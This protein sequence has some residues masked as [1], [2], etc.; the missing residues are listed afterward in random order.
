M[1]MPGQAAAMPQGGQGSQPAATDRVWNVVTAN[2]VIG[3][4]PGMVH[5]FE[6]RGAYPHWR[7]SLAH[8]AVAPQ[9][10]GPAPARQAQGLGLYQPPVAQAG[11]LP[12]AQAAPAADLLAIARAQAEQA[13]ADYVRLLALE[14]DRAR[15]QAAA[16]AAA[17]TAA[18]AQAAQAQAPAVPAQAARAQAAP[19]QAAPAQAAHAAH[20]AQ[21]AQAQAQAAEA[22][23]EGE[24]RPTS[25][26]VDMIDPQNWPEHRRIM[27]LGNLP[28]LVTVQDIQ[29]ICTRAGVPN[30]QVHIFSKTGSSGLKAARAIVPNPAWNML[31]LLLE[32]HGHL[33]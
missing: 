28:S 21:A 30:V 25:I 20:A 4:Q 7:C 2:W 11:P 14:Q 8:Q 32:V 17:A 26:P 19:A 6:H 13:Q 24:A 23:A 12:M 29:D 22:D 18:Q 27:F 5:W 33:S 3:Q 9:V 31:T 1:A 10:Q 15:N 16:D